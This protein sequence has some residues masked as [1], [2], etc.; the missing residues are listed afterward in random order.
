VDEDVV[1]VDRPESSVVTTQQDAVVT[2][3]VAEPVVITDEMLSYV[4]AERSDTEV[5]SVGQVGPPGPQGPPGSGG[6]ASFE[7]QQLSA[8]SSWL[9]NHNLGFRPTVGVFDSGGLEVEADVQH[10]SINQVLISFSTPL[11]GIARL[12]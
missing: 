6:N 9:I 5:V 2:V 10:M 3:V 12:V 11:A 8:S 4:V 1:V 7:F